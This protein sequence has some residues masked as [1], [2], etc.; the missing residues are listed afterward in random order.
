MLLADSPVDDVPS[1]SSPFFGQISP[2][3]LITICSE[4]MKALQRTSNSTN[5]NAIGSPVTSSAFNSSAGNSFSF[6][7]MNGG[8]WIV[9]SR[10]MDHMTFDATLFCSKRTLHTI[11]PVCLPDNTYKSVTI[12]GDILLSSGLILRDVL[13]IPDFKHHLLS[14]GKLLEDNKLVLTFNQHEC[15]F[16]DHTTRSETP[17]V[18]QKDRGLYYLDLAR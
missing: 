5:V 2:S 14:V 18:G 6:S 7:S 9:D 17:T 16:L 3:I 13:F 10:A 1:S 15:T 12:L 4:V 11:L 8:K